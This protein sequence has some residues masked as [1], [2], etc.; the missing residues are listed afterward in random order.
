M[1]LK[2]RQRQSRR[3][4][5]GQ[6]RNV[7]RVGGAQRPHRLSLLSLEPARY[8]RL[9]DSL[10]AVSVSL[11]GA[12]DGQQPLQNGP[13]NRP[14]VEPRF[15]HSPSRLTASI[16][17]TLPFRSTFLGA[18]SRT[19]H[20][21][22]NWRRDA[23]LLLEHAAEVRDTSL[24]STRRRSHRSAESAAWVPPDP[25]DSGHL[26]LRPGRHCPTPRDSR[27]RTPCRVC[28]RLRLPKRRSQSELWPTFLAREAR[29]VA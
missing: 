9:K 16:I 22:L 18:G 10:L 6:W 3:W 25:A 24:I 15:R 17:N 2:G 1:S 11:P 7:H 14:P 4:R 27:R 23:K 8:E 28:H 13:R 19:S 5:S 12:G 20:S 29:T 26:H 21:I